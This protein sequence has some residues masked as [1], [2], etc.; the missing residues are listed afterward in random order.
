MNIIKRIKR[1]K[2][3]R[4]RQVALLPIAAIPFMPMAQCAPPTEFE[5]HQCE[6]AQVSTNGAW[7]MCK[8][9]QTT[10]HGYSWARLVSWC[11]GPSHPYGATPYVNDWHQY[12]GSWFWVAEGYGNPALCNHPNW[13]SDRYY[14]FYHN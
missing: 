13:V 4:L 12:S 10:G 11:Q 14:E 7:G 3:I 8:N 6:V 9:L 2:N 1:I 5:Y